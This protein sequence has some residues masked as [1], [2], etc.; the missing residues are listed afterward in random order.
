[1]LCVRACVVLCARR[2]CVR[3][4][5]YESSDATAMLKRCNARPQRFNDANMNDTRRAGAHIDEEDAR[6]DAIDR[7]VAHV[8]RAR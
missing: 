5:R 2:H 6:W 4:Y 1:M 7:A 8:V 3:V